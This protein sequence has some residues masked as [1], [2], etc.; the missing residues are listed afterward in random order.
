MPIDK[1]GTI[2]AYDAFAPFYSFF[3]KFTHRLDNQIMPFIL[4]T[5]DP[6]DGDAVLD[7]GTGP[8]VYAI[9]IAE[10]ARGAEVYGVDISPRFL[11]IAWQNAQ[12]AGLPQIK[13]VE[14]DLENLPFGDSKFDKLICAG[15]M[16]A[17]PDKERAASELYRVLKPGGCAIFVEPNKGKSIR[18]KL[19]LIALYTMGMFNRGQGGFGI[20]DMPGYYFSKESFYSLF[21]GVG[22]CRVNIIERAGSMCAVCSK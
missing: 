6:R 21:I 8:G 18:D 3:R 4:D 13:F 11:K 1:E 2:N 9:R 10:R 22:F 20:K 15:A 17:V 19:F 12:A 7:A 5:I 16:E 14:G